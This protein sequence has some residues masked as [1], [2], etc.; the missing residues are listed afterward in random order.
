MNH[1]GYQQKPRLLLC[2]AHVCNDVVN[3]HVRV[4]GVADAN[5]RKTKWQKECCYIQT[6]LTTSCIICFNIHVV[7]G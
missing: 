5:G 4:T 1:D 7:L 2:S 3:I 6:V